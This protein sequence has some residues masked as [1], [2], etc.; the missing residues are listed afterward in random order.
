[1]SKDLTAQQFAEEL[2]VTR[3]L[4]YYHAK[5]IAPEEKVY[6][7]EGKLV[8]TP[9][10]QEYLKSFMTDTPFDKEKEDNSVKS[11]G[12]IK[13]KQFADYQENNEKLFSESELVK[14]EFT[15]DPELARQIALVLQNEHQAKMAEKETVKDLTD[16]DNKYSNQD[17]KENTSEKTFEQENKIQDKNSLTNKQAIKEYIQE[18][19]REQLQEKWLQDESERNLLIEELNAKNKQITELHQLLDQ[20]QQLMLMTERKNVKMMETMNYKMIQNFENSLSEDETQGEEI[21]PVINKTWL[22]RLFSK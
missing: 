12:Q 21:N 19:V 8:F 15:Y 9:D 20:Q 7:D 10:Q 2:D 13:D 1:M 5:K 4:I 16:S 6:N 18:I 3:Q 22:Q 17:K 11:N 14:P